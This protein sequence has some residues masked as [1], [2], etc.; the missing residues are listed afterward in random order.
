MI[1]R[2]NSPDVRRTARV[3]V[4]VVPAGGAR[5][6]SPLA[7]ACF[8]AG[9]G[10]VGLTPDRWEQDLEGLLSGFRPAGRWAK[11]A[12]KALNLPRSQWWL[13][14]WGTGLPVSPHLSV[15]GV[16]TG[17]ESPVTGENGH[18]AEL[19]VALA[20]L[21][22]LT[23]RGGT[24]GTVI[25]T[26]ALGQP[27]PDSG[28]TAVEPVAL[29]DS[30]LD[31]ILQQL[32]PDATTGKAKL[33]GPGHLFTPILEPQ[34]D[35]TLR[36]VAATHAGVLA[37]IA[38]FGFTIHHVGSLREAATILGATKLPLE[39]WQ[40]RA[41]A[42]AAAVLALAAGAAGVYG[43][44]RGLDLPLAWA[45]V[46]ELPSPLRAVAVG[47]ADFRPL[48]P[49]VAGDGRPAVRVGESLLLR[50]SAEGASFAALPYAVVWAAENGTVKV[51]TADMLDGGRVA[52]DGALQ[53]PL[54]AVDPPGKGLAA[55]VARRLL[56]FDPADL[57]ERVET[58]MNAAPTP[59]GRL[60][61]AAA[62]LRVGAPGYLAIPIDV[63]PTGD[64]AC[65]DG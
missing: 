31:L 23:H 41:N 24:T 63:L 7:L 33:R 61:A 52:A 49:C 18:S 16:K 21:L 46:E 11:A 45:P 15:E 51:F 42:A 32:R 13:Q 25:A 59:A 56:A 43:Y 64:A 4:P 62:A 10:P 6:A 17:R 3:H 54:T 65:R 57:K 44:D 40:R 27:D 29:L 55:V 39:P 60:N 34:P 48:P 35:G 22:S 9:D 14:R 20:T 58:A 2:A 53:M 1:R 26:G 47:A 28:E 38:A 37:Q 50:A 5:V 8:I 12:V 30:K 19:G 36:P